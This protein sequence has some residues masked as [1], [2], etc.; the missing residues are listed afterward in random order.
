M[1]RIPVGILGATGMVG[2]QF[3]ALLADH[4]WFEVK[5]LGASERSEGK[6][7][8]DA[9]AWRLPNRLPLHIAD[10]IVEAA[11]PGTAPQLVFSGLDSSVAGEIEGEFAKA[12][13]FVVSNSRNY[14]MFDTV[15]L[16]I[17]EVNAEHL[18]LLKCQRQ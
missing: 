6:K 12:G 7:F 9:A 16:L 14:R 1:A 15:P 13:H 18:E 5:F 3:I 17:P 8:K 10:R 4:P 11:R 2:Q